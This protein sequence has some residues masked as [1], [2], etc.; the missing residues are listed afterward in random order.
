MAESFSA[1]R[2]LTG[3]M[4]A[5]PASGWMALICAGYYTGGCTDE[6]QLVRSMAE[7]MSEP[8]LAHASREAC[9]LITELREHTDELSLFDQFMQEYSLDN[10]EGLTL[11]IIAEALLRIPDKSSRDAFIRAEI[12]QADWEKHLSHSP[13]HWVNMATRGLSVSGR[14]A[15]LKNALGRLI[16]R[17]G[18]PVIRNALQY[19]MQMLGN[20]FVLGE[21]ISSARANAERTHSEL[22]AFSFD[23][24]GEA[25]LCDDDAE[26]YLD[27]YRAALKE[28]ALQNEDSNKTTSASKRPCSLSIKLSALH[29][30]YEDTQRED[31][32]V[33]LYDR[34]AT[35]VREA[36]ELSVP[37]TIDAEEADRL[38]LSLELFEQ[39]LRSEGADWG[40][41]G[42]AVQAY[43]KRAL[44][45][46]GW[47]DAL[48]R[49]HAVKIPVRL[50]KG[51]YWDN[52]IK[53]AQQRGL[54]GY[55]VF[56]RKEHTDLSYLAC[57]AFIL[58]SSGIYPQFATH[59]AHTLMA[60]SAMADALSSG[61]TSENRCDVCEYQR[62]Q[63]MGEPLYDAWQSKRKDYVRTYA[64]VGEHKELLPY[65]VRRLL[66]NGAN[67]SFVHHLWK[68]EISP[69]AL[70]QS[71]LELAR[72]HHFAPAADIPAPAKILAP[73]QNS[74]GLNL[75]N[76][77]ELDSLIAGLERWKSY[78]WQARPQVKISSLTTYQPDIVVGC[79]FSA[80]DKVGLVQWA[81]PDDV[82]AIIDTAQRAFT[83]WN[84]E[85]RSAF[86]AQRKAWLLTLADQLETHRHELIMLC[87]RESGKTLQDAVDEIR[88][89]VDF[90]RYYSTFIDEGFAE[91]IALPGP[92]GELNQL[93][94]EGRGVWFCISPWNFPLAIFIGQISAA[95]AAGNAVIA[96]PA[97][98][99]SLIAARAIE[100]AYAAGVPQE[101]LQCVP[102]SGPILG[103]VFCNDARIAGVAF[104]GSHKTA[105]KI[106]MD[107]AH[108]RGPIATFIAETGGQNAM[109]VDSTALPEQVVKDVLRSA[110][111]SAGQRC[112]A[113]RA[114][115]LQA[116]IADEVIRLLK[117]A[118]NELVVGNP[119][120]VSTDV[121]PLISMQ[122]KNSLLA[123]IRH[124]KSHGKLLAQVDNI[125]EEG[126]FLAP[127]AY[128]IG[129]ISELDD[130]HF[131]PILHVIRYQNSDLPNV[132]E[133]INNTGFGLTLSVHSRN[134]EV[135]G[136][137]AR[138]ARVGNVYINR[139]QIGA[140][141]GVQ[142]FGGLGRSGT[143]PKAGG[144]DYVKR[145]ACERTVSVN[146]SAIGGNAE[147]LRKKNQG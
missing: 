33:R 141:V 126:F 55:P 32:K 44:P 3:K 71:P 142:P 97:E 62:L 90:C 22:N 37:V 98:A 99:T 16:T 86:A 115:Y 74:A 101:L 8:L 11:M 31:V 82:Y 50:V 46:L 42:L 30:R 118:M 35:L 7:Q 129:S 41:F 51:A 125:P 9:R 80:Y 131:G 73:R 109:I 59:N 49:E 132:I 144:P 133:D 60:V 122:A 120:D 68:S 29:P 54:P 93:H 53:L 10:D 100:L 79:P 77:D 76:R 5:V 63:G 134:P 104:T 135:S 112:S 83:H 107:L 95:I 146:T 43:S 17:P 106:A 66:E 36:R 72:E 65:L 88:E 143:G 20:Q 84:N 123:H 52:E 96:K 136:F 105:H 128:E 13:S 87:V 124:L 70:A 48:A 94:Y 34:L 108:R 127:V 39:V 102:G 91:P 113:L 56:T 45:V 18:E 114:L 117:G 69:E 89:A 1:E 38:I 61:D 67:T 25:A 110:F 140:V 26:K 57:A 81:H 2:M 24:L 6:T 4:A 137:I 12:S 23:M 27:S 119:G 19:A 75:N 28:I 78:Q 130:E 14:M 139:D 116:D 47:L 138:S 85:P 40:Q 15:R 145:F 121:G 103:D 21:D 111:G 58:K 147:L 92:T 64:P